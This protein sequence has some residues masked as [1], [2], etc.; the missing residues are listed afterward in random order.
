MAPPKCRSLCRIPNFCHHAER[1][2]HRCHFGSCPPCTQLCNLTNPH[3]NHI[4]VLPCHDP[5]PP[6]KFQ[7]HKLNKKAKVLVFPQPISNIDAQLKC[8]PC[9][10]IV[11]RQCVGLHE[12][13]LL[14]IILFNYLI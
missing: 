6:F 1:L 9:P 12:V 4:C 7:E 14:F 13:T 11:Q 2:P 8:P 5:I 10:V 3:C